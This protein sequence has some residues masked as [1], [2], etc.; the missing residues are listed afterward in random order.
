MIFNP[1][2]PPAVLV[3]WIQLRSLAWAGWVTP[4]LS[5]SKLAALIAIHPTRLTKHLSQLQGISALVC[6][7]SGHG[8]I[9]VAFPEEPT[10]IQENHAEYRNHAG[11][12]YLS[13]ENQESLDPPS[14]FPPQILGYLSINE[15]QE[16]SHDYD[17]ADKDLIGD[18]LEEAGQGEEEKGS[19]YFQNNNFDPYAELH[20]QVSQIN[21]HGSHEWV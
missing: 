16:G 19:L 20:N 8:N 13:S 18:E 2:L 11:S 17:L 1:Q 9:I 15:D 5:I 10:V 12:T 6:H 3:T 14:Y 4:P 21:Q 7:T